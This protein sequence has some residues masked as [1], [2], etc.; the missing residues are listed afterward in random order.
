MRAHLATNLPVQVL[1]QVV[2]LALEE[3]EVRATVAERVELSHLAKHACRFDA[4]LDR[5]IS[6]AHRVQLLFAVGAQPE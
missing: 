3:G 2:Q 6:L 1:T 5:L 4:H